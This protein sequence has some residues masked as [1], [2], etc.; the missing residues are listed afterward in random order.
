MKLTLKVNVI[1]MNLIFFFLFFLQPLTHF[2]DLIH[3]TMGTIIYFTN[4]VWGNEFNNNYHDQEE[5]EQDET[6]NQ[7]PTKVNEKEFDSRL[8]IPKTKPEPCDKEL[9]IYTLTHYTSENI[10]KSRYNETM[11]NDCSR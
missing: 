3:W 10:S 1:N 7:M 5:Q 4:T 2:S 6:S 11:S 9:Y 8:L